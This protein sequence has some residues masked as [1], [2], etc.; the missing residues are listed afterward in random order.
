MFFKI[1]FEARKDF[2]NAQR[3]LDINDEYYDVDYDDE[4]CLIVEQRALDI[5][6]NNKIHYC[7]I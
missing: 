2:N 3:V 4:E 1:K 5:L 6:G 7:L